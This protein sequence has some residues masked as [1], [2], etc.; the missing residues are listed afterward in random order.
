MVLNW[1]CLSGMGGDLCF[2]GRVS[3]SLVHQ[4]CSGG[5]GDEL[6]CLS[7]LSQQAKL[8]MYWSV[9]VHGSWPLE[10]GSGYKLPKWASFVGWPDSALKMGWRASTSE[11]SQRWSWHLVR[12]LPFGGFTGN[13]L[14]SSRSWRVLLWRGRARFLLDLLTLQPHHRRAVEDE[15]EDRVMI[16][17]CVFCYFFLNQVICLLSQCSLCLSL[18]MQLLKYL[19]SLSRSC[20]RRVLNQKLLVGCL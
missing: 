5:A 7:P 9:H 8:L 3:G 20:R 15:D 10:K 2:S 16:Y 4:W 6:M 1:K 11:R 17:K 12:M 18:G 13:T 14:A 19:K